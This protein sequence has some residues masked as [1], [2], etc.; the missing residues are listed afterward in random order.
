MQEQWKPVVGFEG[1]YEVS[2]LG[3]VRNFRHKG[4]LVGGIKRNGYRQYVF[5][6]NMKHSYHLAQKL[7][8]EAFV[9]P[10]PPGNQCRHLNGI[11]TDNRLSNLSYGTPKEN[12]HD[13]RAHGTWISG[14]SVKTAKLTD[15]DVASISSRYRFRKV[16]YSMLA[17]EYDVCKCTIANI[18]QGRTWSDLP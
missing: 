2:D 11:K 6:S 8:L 4:I 3:R 18:M 12:Q 7:V 1:L 16:T 13:R 10:R 15:D 14:S 9:G 17:A 5:R